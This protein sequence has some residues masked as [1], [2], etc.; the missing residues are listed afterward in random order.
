MTP[1]KKRKLDETSTTKVTIR[2]QTLYH[3]EFP[4]GPEQ[5]QV[6]Y[7]FPQAAMQFSFCTTRF[8]E[9]DIEINWKGFLGDANED[10]KRLRFETFNTP[11]SQDELLS[12]DL[13]AAFV[14][15]PT[16]VDSRGPPCY[17]NVCTSE[18]SAFGAD[19]GKIGTRRTVNT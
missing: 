10:R 17:D 4:L 14:Q 1:D 11:F 12:L 18:Y 2:D 7:Q 5:Q 13:K 3:R 8:D 15:T 19:N 6:I 16:L 9:A